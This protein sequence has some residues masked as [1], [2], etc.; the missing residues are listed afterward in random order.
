M[1][2]RE[3]PIYITWKNMRQRCSNPKATFYKYYGGRGIS[4]CDRW[5]NF[6]AFS[7]DMLSSYKKGL[8]LDRI[9]NDASYSP[10]NCR[11]IGAREQSNN[12]RNRR[13]ILFRGRLQTLTQWADELGF[14]L[15]TLSQRYY[16]YGWSV[17]KLL[18]KKVF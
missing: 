7:E 17:E 4:V 9:D 10:Q 2:N 15:S 11:W 14:K 13:L 6:Q 18:T 8:T 5:A 1:T 12:R 16:S 3:N